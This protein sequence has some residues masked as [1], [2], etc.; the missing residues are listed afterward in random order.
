ME[1][2]HHKRIFFILI[3]IVFFFISCADN[4]EF[5]KYKTLEEGYWESQK[6]ISFEFLVTD[7][8]SPK[9]LFINIRNNN[10][11]GFSNLYVITELN[12]PSGST[13]VDTLQ[14]K[15]TNEKGRFLGNGFANITENKLFYKE[16]K[17]F[18]RTGNYTIKIRHAMRKSDEV[19]P[20][21]K[22]DGIQDVGFSIEKIN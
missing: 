15:M 20:I 8:I 3:G 10:N 18:P 1:A 4:I 14:Y 17:V 21:A 22:L 12:F 5:T 13:V 9:N 6:N 7:T 19:K 16:N 11:Y 2:I